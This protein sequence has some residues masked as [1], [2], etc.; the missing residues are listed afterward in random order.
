M[1]DFG[2]Y[3]SFFLIFAFALFYGFVVVGQCGIWSVSEVGYS[4]H[5]LDYSMGFASTI[6]PGAIYNFLFSTLNR[7][8][9]SVYLTVLY[10]LFFS[11]VALLLN[12]LYI[13]AKAQNYN[14]SCMVL[15][16]LFLS[17]PC[18][19]SSFLTSFGMLEFYWV[20]FA[21]FFF[22][23]LA[24][25]PLYVLIVPLCVIELLV[26]YSSIICF[27]PFFC[28]LILYKISKEK[29]KVGRIL[30][31]ITFS[32]C[33]VVSIPFA[34]Y[35][36]TNVPNCM[37]YSLEDFHE[38]LRQRGV[39]FYRYCEGQ[40]YRVDE[41]VNNPYLKKLPEAAL[42]QQQGV[43]SYLIEYVKGYAS[44]AFYHGLMERRPWLMVVPILL[45][46]PVVYLIIS[47]LISE[48]KYNKNNKVRRFALFC[49]IAL[50][51]FCLFVSLFFSYDYLKWLTFSMILL[52]S[53][54]L[55]ILFS[56]KERVWQEVNAR[57]SRY[58]K[59]LFVTYLAVYAMHVLNIYY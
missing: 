46:F 15:F 26:N 57:L 38:I 37:K 48:L 11:T 43:V 3:K 51:P 30:L 47:I 36:M 18:A 52:F 25:K 13:S 44:I 34:V 28:I 49:M 7:Q 45:I 17:G 4:Y 14:K 54:F 12:K 10:I 5:A 39:V 59:M 16:F 6:L 35:L 1:K 2:R 19:V 50:F 41:Y 55:Y 42:L 56:E 40:L 32:F 8:Q 27:I 29:D 23:F 21:A 31:W 33:I 20:F 22:I 9:V 24:Y 58:P 53:S